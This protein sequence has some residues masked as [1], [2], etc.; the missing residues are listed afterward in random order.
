MSS[1]HAKGVQQVMDMY[2]M[3]VENGTPFFALFQNRDLIFSC[4]DKDQCEPKLREMLEQLEQGGTKSVFTLKLYADVKDKIN[5]STPENGT[6]RFQ[7]V[8]SDYIAGYTPNMPVQRMPVVQAPNSDLQEIKELLIAQAAAKE[9]VIEAPQKSELERIVDS[10]AT[11]FEKMPV[12]EDILRGFLKQ[13]G[14]PL[15]EGYLQQSQA[16]AG[17]PAIDENNV[18]AAFE[19]L[20][21]YDVDFPNVLI[22]LAELIV[23]DKAKYDLAKQFL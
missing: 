19:T 8:D 6:F 16:L 23:N 15:D 7:V 12:L 13:K 4:C 17:I 3:H 1:I 14:V 18:Q 5:R 20:C 10:V 21:K 9:P 22:K 11:V 2:N